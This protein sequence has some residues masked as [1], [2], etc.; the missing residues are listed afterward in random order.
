MKTSA[1]EVHDMLSVFSVDE[2]EKRIGEV[3]GVRSA[4]VNFAAGSATVRYDETQLEATDIKSA[5]RQRG[6]D[7]AAGP[8]GDGDEGKAASGTPPTA[9]PASLPAGAAPAPPSTAAAGAPAPD[10]AAAPAAAEPAPAE[11]PTAP[12]AAVSDESKD[13]AAPEKS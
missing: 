9:V 12:E 6:F 5:V 3:P 8:A 1:I 4:T 7:P 10:K 13:K 11:P 2:V